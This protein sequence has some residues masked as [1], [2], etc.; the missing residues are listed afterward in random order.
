M[1]KRFNVYDIEGPEN[2]S[3][4]DS[5][6]P[7]PANAGDELSF[8]RR[9]DDKSR[10]DDLRDSIDPFINDSQLNDVARQYLSIKGYAGKT[11]TA[12]YREVKRDMMKYKKENGNRFHSSEQLFRC[13]ESYCCTS[14]K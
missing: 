11:Q 1:V 5:V 12:I 6:I 3:G 4:L 14:K 13:L 2:L 8:A 9:K 7:S 10:M